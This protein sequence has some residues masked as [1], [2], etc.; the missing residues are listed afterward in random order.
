[1]WHL[2]LRIDLMV[3]FQFP[4]FLRAMVEI[5]TGQDPGPAMVWIC[6]L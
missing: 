5:R 2:C 3:L 4:H 1:M 6:F